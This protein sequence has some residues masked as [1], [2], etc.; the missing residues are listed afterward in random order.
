V[1]RL[2]VYYCGRVQGV[3]FRVSVARLA[4]QFDVV[5]RVCNLTDGRVELV[6]EG[7]RNELARFRDAITHEM[8]RYIVEQSEHWSPAT[9]LWT[10]FEIGSDK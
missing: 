2:L 7:D 6:A 1:Q 9:Q 8:K 10:S 3:G 4:R 5:G